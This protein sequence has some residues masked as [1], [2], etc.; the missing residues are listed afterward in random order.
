MR[1]LLYRRRPVPSASPGFTLVEL[2]VVIGIIA[3]L[4]GILLP[5]LNRARQSAKLVSC[6]SNIRQTTTAVA[7]YIAENDGALPEA[8]F[9]NGNGFSP[10]GSGLAAWSPLPITPAV[11]GTA[12][13]T[14]VL[15][16]IGASLEDYL[17][18]PSPEGDSAWRCPDGGGEPINIPGLNNYTPYQVEGDDPYAGFDGDDVFV[19]NYYY[20]ANKTFI[21]FSDPS[22]AATRVKPGFPGGD[23]LVRNI[24]GLRAGSA[25][26]V[27][28]DGSSDVVVFVEYESTFHTVDNGKEIY[29]LLPGETA[30]YVGNYGYLDGHAKTRS[31][32]DRDGY[33]A[34]FSNPI[35]QRWYGVDFASAFAE[36]YDPANFYRD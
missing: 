29:N 32:R 8:T 7:G 3:L 21:T 34:E 6:L 31:Y 26:P 28:G 19:P 16:S 2:L 12:A 24:A 11:T 25:K 9:N 15:P 33:T 35:P 10:A 5:T 13:D 20:M 17:G 22:V 27:G 36:F 23:W 1:N 14:Y 30:E 18:E 4:I